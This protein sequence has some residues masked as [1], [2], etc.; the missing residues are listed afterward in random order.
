MPENRPVRFKVIRQVRP[1][2]SLPRVCERGHRTGGSAEPA[3]ALGAIKDLDC[4]PLNGAVPSKY[5]DQLA[6]VRQSATSTRGRKSSCRSL[7]SWP[8]LGRSERSPLY[9]LACGQASCDVHVYG[10]AQKLPQ[11]MTHGFPG[12]V[13]REIGENQKRA[14]L[15]TYVRDDRTPAGDTRLHRRSWSRLHTR[16]ARREQP[17]CTP[18]GTHIPRAE[19]LQPISLRRFEQTLQQGSTYTQKRPCLGDIYPSPGVIPARSGP[20]LRPAH[21]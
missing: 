1:K 13:H 18:D 19:I 10:P 9:R 4:W 16:S 2:L 15:W 20:K 12:C 8:R 17:Q 14:R 3:D 6:A 21:P 7:D 11:P 5:G